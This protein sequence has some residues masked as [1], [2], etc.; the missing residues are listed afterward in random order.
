MEIEQRVER[1]QAI[2]R[3]M[4][5]HLGNRHMAAGS[6]PEAWRPILIELLHDLIH[7]TDWA[8]INYMGAA[9]AARAA[10]KA[11]V[12]P[13]R[14]AQ[15]RTHEI[16]LTHHRKIYP[17]GG[18]VEGDPAMTLPQPCIHGRPAH[19]WCGECDFSDDTESKEGL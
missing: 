14:K 19:E 8:G 18:V 15:G 6:P 3:T 11:E 12:E 4:G 5:R 16:D 7:F 2:M 9:N 17:S 10:Y 1:A 13:I